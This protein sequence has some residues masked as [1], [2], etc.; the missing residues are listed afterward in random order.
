M[1]AYHILKPKN[2]SL[3]YLVNKYNPDFKFNTDFAY[4]I[5]HFVIL[6]QSNKSSNYTRLHSKYLQK[7]NRIYNKHIQFLINNFPNDGAVLRGTRYDKGKPFGYKL[8]KYYSDSELEI[9]IITDKYLLR[10]INAIKLKSTTNEMIRLNYY[11][12]LKYFKNGKLS[13]YEPSLLMESINKI[14]DKEKRLRNAKSIIKIMNGDTKL[15]LKPKTDGRVHSNITRLSKN[16][17]NHLQYDGE[18]LA[19]VDISS[20]IPFFLLLIMKYYITDRLTYVANEFQYYNSIIYILDKTSVCIVNTDVDDFG[21]SVLKKQLYQR[22]ADEIFKEEVYTSKGH[23]FEKVM[24]YYNYDFKKQF[25]YHFDGDMNDLVKF[26]KKRLLSMLFARTYS[27]KFEQL[28]FGSIFPQVLK[29]INAFKDVEQ[30]SEDNSKERHKKIAYCTFQF[31]AKTMIDKIA[32]EF[33]KIHNDKVPVFTLH[34]CLI[35]TVSHVE[36]LKYFMEKKFIELFEVAPNLTIEKS[37]FVT[38]YQ[39]VS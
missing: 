10:K 30:N 34:D 35:T 6:Y 17:R 26:A 2:L 18:F 20:S 24:K 5:I 7:F 25:G 21:N 3:E 36:E 4:L 28:A 37:N 9:H 29:F 16:A 8:P 39:K 33:D 22:F 31:E 15:T 14:S 12:L 27:Y 32:R 19:E 1:K 23:N 13:I 38:D 11:F